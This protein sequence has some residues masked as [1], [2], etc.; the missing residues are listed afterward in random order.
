MGTANIAI[1]GLGRAGE[2]FLEQLIRRADLGLNIVCAVEK[3]ANSG[4]EKAEQS[5]IALLDIDDVVR[6]DVD[7]DFI[8]NLTGDPQVQVDLLAKLAADGNDHTEVVSDKVLKVI[9]S[10]MSDNPIPAMA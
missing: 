10:I 2:V 1:I 8:F 9:W 6:F 3:A 4:R 7:I 5:G